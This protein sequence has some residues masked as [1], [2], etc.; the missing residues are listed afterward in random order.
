MIADLTNHLWQSTLVAFLAALLITTLRNN[1]GNVRYWVWFT[2]SCKFFV[3]FVLLI[4]LGVH[5][6]WPPTL[7][8]IATPLAPIVSPVPA[9]SAAAVFPFATAATQSSVDW[10]HVILF[11][12]WMCG[13]C[14]IALTRLHAWRRIRA[15]LRRSTPLT[16]P[17]ISGI[18][19]KVCS[20][21]DLLEPS[22]VGLW[23]PV[24]LMPAGVVE[25]LAPPQLEAVLAH[26]LCHVRRRDNLTAAIHMI[27]EALFWFHPLVW[28]IGARLLDERE[29]ACDEH[30]LQAFQE[31]R[32]YA[33]GILN[34]CK[35]YGA[36]PL[37]CVSGVTGS[38]NVKKRIEDIM[39]NRVGR[40]LN[41]SKKAGLA[42][43][44][45]VTI[46]TPIGMGMLTVPLRAQT[47]SSIC[48]ESDPV[49][50][51]E[52]QEADDE[53]LRIDGAAREQRAAALA[54]ELT[55]RHP[56]DFI[57]HIRYQQWIRGTTGAA[58]LIKRYKT[59][60]AAHPGNPTFTVLY[61][62]A[63]R[64]TNGPKA[65]ELIKSVPSSPLDPWA[66]LTLAEIYSTESPA[67]LP[68]A[69]THLD[70]WFGACPT[71]PN[72]NAL[73]SLVRYGSPATV[74]EE[75]TVLRTQFESETD[76]HLLLSWQFVWALEFKARP[77]AEQAELRKQIAADVARLEGMPAPNDNRWPALL[78][79]GHKLAS[80]PEV[81]QS[82]M[83]T[84]TATG[85]TERGVRIGVD[86]ANANLLTKVEPEY[87][88][89][90]QQA[91]IQGSVEFN[92]D[93]GSDGHVHALE[94]VRGHP[95]LVQAA[96]DAVLQWVYRPTLLD[97]KPVAVTTSVIIPFSLSQ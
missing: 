82:N 89:L 78:A 39:N 81:Q 75:A 60:A 55:D 76:P 1:T 12:L 28:W 17:G 6:K 83:R 2:A 20:S 42:L 92:V 50:R 90:A 91:R 88:P 56:D 53:I 31:P 94:L 4:N 8:K 59:L 34:V 47:S 85:Q 66:H 46:V 37:S 43:A 29:R 21:S 27:V 38:T 80:D 77:L 51:L 35:L 74:A 84:L 15:L 44:A 79:F 23:N 13:F 11:G 9:S 58:T 48:A 36:S 61:A 95:L 67:N 10:A 93:I 97:G 49:I 87:P 5:L 57:V 62:Q 63:L 64:D 33:E 45:T 70:A 68:E 41:I 30:V 18:G 54:Q 26:E 16:V 22:V 65:I 32:A 71:T 69:S 3:P 72:W 86:V 73:S 40:K 52:I 24:L 96:K 25:C 14:G 7:D 19:L